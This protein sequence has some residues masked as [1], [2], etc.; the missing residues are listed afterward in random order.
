MIIIRN[1]ARSR[2]CPACE[3]FA[4]LGERIDRKRIGLV[5]GAF[6]GLHRTLGGA[7]ATELNDILVRCP[8]GI[9]VDIHRTCRQGSAV[10]IL[11]VAAL[12][13]CPALERVAGLGE[14][15]GIQ[16]HLVADVECRRLHRTLCAV[17]V[18]GQRVIDSLPYRRQS[19]VGIRHGCGNRVVFLGAGNH[20]AL[21]RIA[22]LGGRRRRCDCV[23]VGSGNRRDRR[24]A[25]GIEGDGVAQLLPNRK[26]LNIRRSDGEVTAVGIGDDA[27]LRFCP[28]FEAVAFTGKGVAVE[29]CLG[30]VGENLRFHFAVAAVGVEG[31]LI[32]VDGVV[33]FENQ[34]TL[35][36]VHDN[37]GQ[38]V[39]GIFLV[40]GVAGKRIADCGDFRVD[41]SRGLTAVARRRRIGTVCVL[42]IILRFVGCVEIADED[43]VCIKRNVRFTCQNRIIGNLRAAFRCGKPAGKFVAVANRCTLGQDVVGVADHGGGDV[44]TAFVQ[45][46]AHQL[47]CDGHIAG[48]HG[49][50]RDGGR[51]LFPIDFAL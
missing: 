4:C 12:R 35:V 37:A 20:P 7:V 13:Q 26:Q 41:F 51:C 10:H 11:H 30:A 36:V 34:H 22:E 16:R 47:P 17:G 28:A 32:A 5:I 2:G 8:N 46:A 27:V 25:V 45:G 50:E 6:H 38:Y 29:V 15:Y 39:F 14:L 44:V 49:I 18:V 9:Q 40:K 33:H 21:E 43:P 1:C 48:P 23:V 31:N 24:A 3:R 42:Q 19:D